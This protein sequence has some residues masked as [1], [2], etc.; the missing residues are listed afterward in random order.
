MAIRPPSARL[1]LIAGIS[2]LVFGACSSGPANAPAAAPTPAV[3]PVPDVAA[4]PAPAPKPVVVK[5]DFATQVKPFF[6]KY[7]YE[8][9]GPTINLP[10]GGVNMGSRRS[11]LD[12][13][14]PGSPF[15]SLLFKEIWNHKMPLPGHPQPT[16]AEIAMMRQWI[17]EGAEWPV[18]APA[19]Q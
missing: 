1:I 7:C 11:V 6:T 15:T 8:C 4:V 16:V 3:T 19:A 17:D 9:H 13:I 5:V 10:P 2:A 12:V 14:V 18:A